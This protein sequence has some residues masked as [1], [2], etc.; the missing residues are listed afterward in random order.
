MY[1]TEV[2]EFYDFYQV[3]DI[4]YPSNKEEI[5]KAYRKLARIYHPDMQ[6]NESEYYESSEDFYKIDLAYQTLKEQNSKENYDF[7][8]EKFILKT[9]YLTENG[10]CS[11]G[12]SC[13]PCTPTAPPSNKMIPIVAIIIIA[14][15]IF[16]L[17]LR[18][19]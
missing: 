1:Y 16:A 3:L 11:T 13:S 9:P 12:G 2:E 17:I 5:K 19:I 8:Y 14:S 15:M 6:N 18:G 10:D 4:S 7:L